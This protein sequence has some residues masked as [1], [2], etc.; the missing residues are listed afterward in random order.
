MLA[1]A[2]FEG[3]VG[4]FDSGGVAVV[5]EDDIFSVSFQDSGVPFGETGAESRNDIFDTELLV[6]D[7]V[8][9]YLFI[10]EIGHK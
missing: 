6:L 9:L 10:K 1:E 2:D 8:E 3:T 7:A 4:G 5:N